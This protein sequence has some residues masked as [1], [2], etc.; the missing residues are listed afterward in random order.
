MALINISEWRS[1]TEEPKTKIQNENPV[2][3]AWAVILILCVPLPFSLEHFEEAML[4]DS[5]SMHLKLIKW[6]LNHINQEFKSIWKL[7]E[8]ISVGGLTLAAYIGWEETM[9]KVES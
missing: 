3:N 5:G 2:T 8:A 9:I 4:V 6:P 1:K 7:V